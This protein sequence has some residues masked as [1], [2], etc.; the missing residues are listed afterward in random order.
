MLTIEVSSNQTVPF[1]V[2]DDL[3]KGAKALGVNLR[4]V[5]QEPGGSVLDQIHLEAGSST[6]VE[7]VVAEYERQ[8]N[9]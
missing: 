2:A 4:L 6:T 1:V 7:A 3:C 5:M 8:M 9:P